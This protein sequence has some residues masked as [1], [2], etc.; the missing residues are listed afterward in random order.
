MSLGTALAF[1]G[2]VRLWRCDFT[3]ALLS[4]LVPMAG[5]RSTCCAIQIY[6]RVGP[7]GRTLQ[8]AQLVCVWYFQRNIYTLWKKSERRGEI[9]CLRFPLSLGGREGVAVGASVCMPVQV[10]ALVGE[11]RAAGTDGGGLWLKAVC[12]K[13]TRLNEVVLV[14]GERVLGGRGVRVEGSEVLAG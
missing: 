10:V 8:C 3:P 5:L 1:G 7:L 12:S 2:F 14:P 11:V 6:G 4:G 13:Q 9:L